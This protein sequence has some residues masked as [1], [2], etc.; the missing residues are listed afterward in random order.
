M[1]GHH[2]D[3]VLQAHGRFVQ[4]AD[5]D[6]ALRAELS[7]VV[8]DTDQRMRWTI[9]AHQ[10][11]SPATLRTLKRLSGWGTGSRLHRRLSLDGTR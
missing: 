1:T 11:F 8:V 5:L 6:P 9:L 7:R 3:A 10:T 4:R 2:A